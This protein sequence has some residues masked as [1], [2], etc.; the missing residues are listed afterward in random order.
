MQLYSFTGKQLNIQ[1]NSISCDCKNKWLKSWLDSIVDKISTS[2]GVN[3]L[4]PEWL[5][6]KSVILLNE[7]EFGG[8][9]LYTKTDVLKTSLSTTGAF[10]IFSMMVVLS[11]RVFRFKHY[12][13]TK[14]HP[15]DRDECEGE[16]MAHDV[17]LSCSSDDSQVGR[18]ILNLLENDGY[19]VCYHERDFM[20]GT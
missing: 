9:S 14:I 13:Y 10:L 19:K 11:F 2:T 7:E 8:G 17:F 3:C 12:R 15:F 18:K 20:P 5:K 6:S 4:T 1:N 16:D